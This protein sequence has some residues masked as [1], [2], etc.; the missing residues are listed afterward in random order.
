MPPEPDSDILTPEALAIQII[1]QHPELAKK[2][3]G[4]DMSALGTLEEKA[5]A[6]GAGRLSEQEIKETL[7]RKLG[8]SY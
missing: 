2:Y 7:M 8:A 5:L 6:L 3:A 4:G 1:D